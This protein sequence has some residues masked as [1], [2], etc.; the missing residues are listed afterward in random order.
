MNDI[1]L[2]KFCCVNDFRFYLNSPMRTD[3]GVVATNGHILIC[4]QSK[5]EYP[6]IKSDLIKKIDEF[7]AIET[8]GEGVNLDDLEL[9]E[10]TI[11]PECVDGESCNVDCDVCNGEGSF[12]MGSYFYDCKECNGSGSLKDSAIKDKSETCSSCYGSGE[13]P[14][15]KELLDSGFLVSYLRLLKELPNCTLYPNKLFPAK[16]IFDGGWGILMPMIG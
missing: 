5:D 14:V 15:R 8:M 16:F 6:Q 3:H 12:Q 10:K 7:N 9:P 4:V 1:D 11:C 13:K 2:K